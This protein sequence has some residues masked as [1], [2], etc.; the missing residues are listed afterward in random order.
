MKKVL[1]SGLVLVVALVLQACGGSA[2]NEF[3]Y[4]I[5]ESYTEYITMG[6]SADYAPFESLETINGEL[7]IVG[8]DVL[9]AKEI[10]TKL[11]KNL[12]LVNRKFDYLIEDLNR[13]KVDFVMA[14]LTITEKRSKVVNF[15]EFYYESQDVLLV[16]KDNADIYTSI[17]AID[18]STNKIATQAGT[19]QVNSVDT[20]FNNASKQFVPSYIDLLNDLKNKKVSGLVLDQPVAVAYSKEFSDLVISSAVFPSNDDKFAIAVNKKSDDL[21]NTINEVIKEIKENGKLDSF[22]KE[23]IQ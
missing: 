8:I 2:V 1:L 12:K 18:L 7:T 5:D 4:I 14:G 20:L 13:G 17:E 15:S 3:T 9:I 6:T 11:E 23:I 19:S 16:H 22:F 10:A 21:L